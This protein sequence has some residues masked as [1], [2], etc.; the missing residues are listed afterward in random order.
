MDTNTESH[1]RHNEGSMDW[2]DPSFSKYNF[3]IAP[4]DKAQWTSVE[5]AG[6][7]FKSNCTMKSTVRLYT[8]EMAA[9]TRLFGHANM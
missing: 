6:V 2:A 5:G 1:T 7:G 4:E 3:N 9:K 8:L